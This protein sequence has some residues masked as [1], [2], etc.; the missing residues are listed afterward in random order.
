MILNF[1]VLRCVLL[2]DI[3]QLHILLAVM[4]GFAEYHFF[5]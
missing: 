5:G 4:F 2:N 3:L 1:Y